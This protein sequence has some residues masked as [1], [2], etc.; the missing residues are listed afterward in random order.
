MSIPPMEL[1]TCEYALLCLL[2]LFVWLTK[3]TV[4]GTVL[5]PILTVDIPAIGPG[6]SQKLFSRSH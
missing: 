2:L 3:Y 1:F 6:D 5:N 4:V